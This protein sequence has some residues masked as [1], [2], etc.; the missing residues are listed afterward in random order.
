MYLKVNSYCIN[1]IKVS[2]KREL[3]VQRTKH[4]VIFNTMMRSSDIVKY[5]NCETHSCHKDSFLNFKRILFTIYLK[6]CK[7]EA[8]IRCWKT[9]NTSLPIHLRIRRFY[10]FGTGH[11]EN[12]S[13]KWK[14]SFC[15]EVKF[16]QSTRLF[17]NFLDSQKP[18]FKHRTD[19]FYLDHL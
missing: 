12:K 6:I 5:E 15:I 13:T 9:E 2:I 4:K 18:W 1:R 10:E 19:H 17:Y 8:D 14:S 3:I 16:V 7:V 11:S